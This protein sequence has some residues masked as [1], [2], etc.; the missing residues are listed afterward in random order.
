[1]QKYTQ[2]QRQS[3]KD[4]HKYY[5]GLMMRKNM[6]KNKDKYAGMQ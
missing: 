2:K 6:Q 4:K 1:M 5:L 3:R